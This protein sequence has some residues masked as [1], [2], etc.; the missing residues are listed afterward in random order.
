M[1][2]QEVDRSLT[3]ALHHLMEVNAKINI[4]LISLQK[5]SGFRRHGSYDL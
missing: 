5:C 1:D 3:T 4:C 2:L